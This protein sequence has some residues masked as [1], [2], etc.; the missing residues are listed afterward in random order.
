M[1]RIKVGVNVGGE[2]G[3][4]PC[5]HRRGARRREVHRC[6]GSEPGDTEPA[7]MKSDVGQNQEDGGGLRN[8]DRRWRETV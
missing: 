7:P 3:R 2:R 1:G 4:D 8:P 5:D 6:D